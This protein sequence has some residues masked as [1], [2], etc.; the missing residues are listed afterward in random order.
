MF[1]GCWGRRSG[2]GWG[3]YQPMCPPHH[4]IQVDM[5]V[6]NDAVMSQTKYLLQNKCRTCQKLSSISDSLQLDYCKG[7]CL[8]CF[9]QKSNNNNSYENIRPNCVLPLLMVFLDISFH[10]VWS[11]NFTIASM[12]LSYP[13][14][15]NI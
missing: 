7:Y 10:F 1:K 8:V 6:V 3:M 12:P 15:K 9:K 2:Y 11:N 13:P 14:T 4:Q 5:F